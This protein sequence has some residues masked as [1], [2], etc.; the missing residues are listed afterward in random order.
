MKC[1]MLVERTVSSVLHCLPCFFRYFVATSFF[2][3][4][5]PINLY[6]RAFACPSFFFSFSS[7]VS[8]LVSFP[9]S[10]A[11]L[12]SL[13]LSFR[14]VFSPLSRS[15]PGIECLIVNVLYQIDEQIIATRRTG[16]VRLA[17]ESG[18]SLV[19]S[20]NI[21]ANAFVNRVF[22]HDSV[23][24]SISRKIRTSLVVWTDAFGIPFGPFPV[25]QK[26]C[27]VLGP[28]IH[29]ERIAKPTDEQ[30]LEVQKSALI[31]KQ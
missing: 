6:S 19:P 29:C 14:F 8:L 5:F 21:G 27:V 13:F 10:L 24:A 28:A 7:L 20:Y 16:L 12:F 1:F 2:L 25:R 30:V 31:R 22:T 4:P 26:M 9:L 18:A 17:I 15:L 11:Y 3:V 23:L